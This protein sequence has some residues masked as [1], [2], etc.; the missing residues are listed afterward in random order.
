MNS[1][2]APNRELFEAFAA[3]RRFSNVRHLRQE[4]AETMT[5]LRARVKNFREGQRELTTSSAQEVRESVLRMLQLQYAM[6]EACESIPVDYSDVKSRIL[7]DFDTELSVAY[8]KKVNEWL[9]MIEC[10]DAG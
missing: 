4:H 3:D 5:M 2:E 8:L 9:R 7:A 1:L 6:I 10:S